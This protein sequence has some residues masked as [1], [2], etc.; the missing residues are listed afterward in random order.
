MVQTSA[1]SD[2]S[3]EDINVS[4]MHND[5]DV[6]SA[7]CPGP[8]A[9]G[10]QEWGKCTK[11]SSIDEWT[12]AFH[13]LWENITRGSDEIPGCVADNDDD[14]ID[15]KDGVEAEAEEH[16]EE[17]LESTTNELPEL[18]TIDEES[19]NDMSH[20]QG[21]EDEDF[22]AIDN[23][24]REFSK[25]FE[26][27]KMHVAQVNNRLKELRRDIEDD[28]EDDPENEL[29]YRLDEVES[30]TD[31]L[32]RVYEE[33]Y[34]I[35]RYIDTLLGNH[36]QWTG[37]ELSIESVRSNMI[38]NRTGV[39]QPEQLPE[40]YKEPMIYIADQMDMICDILRARDETGL[41]QGPREDQA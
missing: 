7:R 24:F 6:G 13:R 33:E 21:G 22:L 3:P 31:Y 25:N 1:N 16:T 17:K 11:C 30:Y 29:N 4:L 26:S 41:V 20:R 35:I 5:A 34:S 14:E 9:Q 39:L 38:R 18:D 19:S 10:P 23:R 8:L 37:V 15:S 28:I 27:T 2:K 32:E 40:E 12:S 36:P